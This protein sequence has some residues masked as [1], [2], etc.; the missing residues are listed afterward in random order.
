ML[1]PDIEH[2]GAADG[3]TGSCHQLH[4]DADN[5]LLID[6]GLFQGN[7]A[8]DIGRA[9]AGQAAIEF[10]LATV[11]ALIVTHVHIDHVGRL[12]Q[13]LAAGFKGPILCTTACARVDAS[14]TS[15]PCC[16][17]PGTICSSATKRRELPGTPFSNMVRK[18]VAM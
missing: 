5:S 17:I 15:K 2:H 18:K 12:P 16:T 4:M 14:V 9:G 7:E 6:C 8:P 13:L 10:G 11:R 1:L 3:V